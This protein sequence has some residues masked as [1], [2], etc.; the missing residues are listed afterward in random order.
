[1]ILLA[2]SKKFVIVKMN[3]KQINF[4]KV[5]ARSGKS[6]RGL[7]HITVFELKQHKTHSCKYPK[8]NHR[9]MKNFPQKCGMKGL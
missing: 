5:L 6:Q 4:T 2:L 9:P 7:V 8:S 1:M 3:S